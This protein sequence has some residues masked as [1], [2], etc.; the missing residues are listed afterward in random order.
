[1]RFRVEHRS[2]ETIILASSPQKMMS[3]SQYVSK[4]EG[5][6][7]LCGTVAPTNYRVQG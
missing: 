1:M 4:K 7:S 6:G 3:Y 5:P 2:L